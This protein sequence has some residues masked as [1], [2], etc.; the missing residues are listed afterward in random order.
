MNKHFSFRRRSFRFRRFTRKAY[1]AFASIHREVSIGRV[2]NHICDREMLKAGRSIAACL[3]C[4]LSLNTASAADDSSV[5][6]PDTEQFTIEEVMV[7]AQKAETQ[8]QNLRVINRLSAEQIKSLPVSTVTDLLDYLPGIDARSRGV[9]G[10]QTDISIRGGSFDQ[11]VILLN[12]QNMT[13][14]T[15]LTYRLI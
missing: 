5:P 13:D 7:V 1:A 6:L 9:N 12:G 8:S 3:L 15:P 2:S 11:T 4:C 10:I 14:L